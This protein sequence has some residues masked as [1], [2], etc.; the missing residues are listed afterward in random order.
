MLQYLD[1]GGD[2]VELLRDVAADFLKLTTAGTV[3]F[4]LW[5]V[6]DDRHPRQVRGNGFTARRIFGHSELAQ[7][8]RFEF[9][10]DTADGLQFCERFGFVEQLS[11]AGSD[12]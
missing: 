2:V 9:D 12:L 7:R 11:L 6:M 1:F 8:R 10:L 4:V 5:D 3:A